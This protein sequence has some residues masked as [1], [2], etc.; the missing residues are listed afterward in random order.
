MMSFMAAWRFLTSIPIPFRKED[1]NRPLSHEQFARSLVYYPFIGLLIGGILC[2]LYWLFSQFLPALLANALLLGSLVMITGA[3]HLDGVVDTFDG[4][5]GGHRSPERRKQIMKEP[6]VGAIGVVV[7]VVL[8]V[9]KY[10]ALISVPDSVIY[11]SLVI[12]PVISRWAMVYAVFS[13]PYAR[14]Q[15][16]GKSLKEGS[17]RLVLY[18]ASISAVIIVAAAGGWRGLIM[19]TL[20]WILTIGM[21]HYFRGKFQGLTGDSYGTINEVSEFAVLLLVVLFSFNNWL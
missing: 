8:L 7:V 5:A 10:A 21:A 6:G 1:W 2:A 20:V 12:M 11:G 3:L 14:E 19:M 18:L 4:L 15:G 9:L 17:G 16:M 13:Y